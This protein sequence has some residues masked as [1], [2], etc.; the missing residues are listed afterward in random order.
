MTKKRW[1]LVA[2]VVALCLVPAIMVAQS[3]FFGPEAISTAGEEETPVVVTDADGNAHI[4]WSSQ[5]GRYLYYKM[6]DKEGNV[7]IEETNLTPTMESSE[8]HVRRP[9]AALDR[10]GRLHIVFHAW[11]LYTGFDGEKYT[12]ST[13]LEESEVIYT[14]IDPSAY[15]AKARAAGPAGDFIVVPEKIISGEDEER[16]RAPNIAYDVL[17]DWLYVVW[18]NGNSN[19]NL[20]TQYRVLDS[21]GNPVIPV[22]TPNGG[23]T[24]NISW[25]EPELA[26]NANGQASIVY[27][28][29][30]GGEITRQ[31]E[32]R[33][34]F[35]L[36]VTVEN[37]TGVTLIA[38]TR[39]TE[40]DGHAS[41]KAK[42]ALD[43]DGMVHVVWHDSR[44]YDESLMGESEH[45]IYYS[46][47]KPV[48]GE[49]AGDG[50]PARQV[51]S[52]IKL[53]AEVRITSDD[54]YQSY[55][56]NVFVDPCGR[57]HVVWADYRNDLNNPE[58]YYQVFNTAGNQVNQ[59]IGET[60]LTT[61]GDSLDP[62]YWLESSERTPD[63]AFYRDTLYVVFGGWD[64][65]EEASNIHLMMVQVEACTSAC[66]G[67][68]SVEAAKKCFVGQVI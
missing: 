50:A 22:I 46:K 33:E 62:V 64:D 67:K 52:I 27:C 59:I 37:G 21:S 57:V 35:Y 12:D 65:E 29:L 11:S 15:R 56:A 14:Q 43:C 61:S 45:E 60:R 55:Q 66:G 17:N 31:E 39:I 47:L 38:D 2:L 1:T 36:M 48:P 28:A 51:G 10:H 25:G 6:V 16:S 23:L 8:Y 44:L 18:F 63:I 58:L 49:P 9:S 5:Y 19:S 42:L 40:Q 26:V 34:I 30:A 32:S 54:G 68:I 3:V 13:E 7:L 24:V 53:I 4:V 20:A 41:V